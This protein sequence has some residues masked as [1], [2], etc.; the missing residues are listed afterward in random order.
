MSCDKLRMGLLVGGLPQTGKYDKLLSVLGRREEVRLG[1]MYPGAGKKL[2]GDAEPIKTSLFS[3]EVDGVKKTTGE[4]LFIFEEE[5]NLGVLLRRVNGRHLDKSHILNAEVIRV[6]RTCLR[7]TYEPLTL[8]AGEPCS[9]CVSVLDPNYCDECLQVKCCSCL[10]K[11]DGGEKRGF[12]ELVSCKGCWESM[13]LQE[14]WRQSIPVYDIQSSYDINCHLFLCPEAIEREKEIMG[15]SA[16]LPEEGLRPFMISV[17]VSDLI[18]PSS[19][20]YWPYG[21][22]GYDYLVSQ[23][24]LK[25]NNPVSETPDCDWM[26]IEVTDEMLHDSWGKMEALKSKYGFTSLNEPGSVPTTLTKDYK[27]YRLIPS[28]HGFTCDSASCQA[29][30]HHCDDGGAY[31]ALIL[32][33]LPIYTSRS[34]DISSDDVPNW[35]YGREYC[36]ACMV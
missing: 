33:N 14:K 1:K 9:S 29:I 19:Q 11:I 7:D 34:G 10:K 4:A 30:N 31:N 13:E 36:L 18:D 21:M 17:V 2:W 20:Y 32:P 25:F 24:E 16:P 3:V 5:C 22:S 28:I 12:G 23:E 8:R 26:D 27:E 15:G 35:G 6:C